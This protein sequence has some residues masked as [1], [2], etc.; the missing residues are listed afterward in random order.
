MLKGISL[1]L[2]L[3]KFIFYLDLSVNLQKQVLWKI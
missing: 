2:R 1:Q 3:Q